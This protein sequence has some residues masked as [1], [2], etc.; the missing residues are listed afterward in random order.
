MKT[1][2]PDHQGIFETRKT[3]NWA[4]KIQK[5]GMRLINNEDGIGA[6]EFALLAPVLLLVYVGTVE[7]STALTVDKRI[8]KA[9]AIT[10]DIIA[11]LESV[12]KASLRE[13]VGVAQSI[14]A[15]YDA[16]TLRFQVVGIN[17]NSSGVATIA[18]SWNS[19]AVVPL[20]VGAL[21]TIPPAYA[22]PDTFLLRTVVDMDYDLVLLS[23]KSGG[24]EYKTKALTLGEDYFLH[25]RE[26]KN[27]TCSDC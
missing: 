8:T 11:N 26:A 6:V 2:P 25:Q 14:V 15:P 5:Y 4:K 23:P 24:V 27:I 12:D 9:S 18:W 10:T 17:V 7:L 1:L 21:I 20:V 19:A 3:S 16:S 13:M 22:I